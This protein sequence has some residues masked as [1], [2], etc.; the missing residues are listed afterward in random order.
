MADPNPGT[1]HAMEES[2]R[3]G[4]HGVFERKS[5]ASKLRKAA[6]KTKKTGKARK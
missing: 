6:P 2:M 5:G 3:E 4:G 1:V